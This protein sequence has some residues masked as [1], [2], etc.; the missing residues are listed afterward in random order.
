MACRSLLLTAG[1]LLS[2]CTAQT[3]LWRDTYTSRV[4]ALALLQ[5]LNSELLASSSA[6][7]TLERWCTDHRMAPDS[8]IV[9]VRTGTPNKAPSNE[10]LQRLGV[11]SAS[12]VRYRH[13]EL[14]CGTHVFSEADNWYVPARLT[15][16]MNQLLEMTDTPFGKVVRPLQPYRR[17]LQ[18]TLIWAPLAPGWE[19]RR[20][21]RASGFG[22]GKLTIPRDVLEHRAL[23]YTADHQPFAEVVERYRG[24]ML[25]FRIDAE[26]ICPG[27]DQ[28]RR[29]RASCRFG[30]RVR[31][32]RRK[33]I[34]EPR[35]AGSSERPRMEHGRN[36]VRQP[37]Y[38]SAS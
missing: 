17:T 38:R 16:E 24:E 25:A 9:A 13:V 20:P 28:G 19:Q 37:A 7:Q 10:Q 1:L 23:L 35:A 29:S 5:T 18:T 14:R 11:T 3:A 8:K 36:M 21:R 2:S 6:T 27:G 30:L 15:P 26:R 12:D 4:E 22:G 34:V 32:R 33:R 31:D